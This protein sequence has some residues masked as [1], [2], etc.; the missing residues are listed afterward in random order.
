[1]KLEQALRDAL[2]E[3]GRTPHDIALTIGVSPSTITRFLNR[4]ST[5]KLE[6]IDKLLA[7]LGLEVRPIDYHEED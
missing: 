5:L 4:Q 1:M 2:L 3:N 7:E 6:T